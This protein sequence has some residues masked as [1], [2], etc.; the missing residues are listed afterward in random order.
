MCAILGA[1]FL[2]SARIAALRCTPSTHITNAVRVA[3]EIRV[4]TSPV[5]QRARQHIWPATH[6]QQPRS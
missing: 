4:A 5:G 1:A 3:G 2:A 6:S